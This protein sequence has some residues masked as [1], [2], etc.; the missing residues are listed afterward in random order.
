MNL[1]QPPSSDA[2]LF[3]FRGTF[4]DNT[5]IN[6][7][8]LGCGRPDLIYRNVIGLFSPAFNEI[9]YVVQSLDDDTKEFEV[10]FL[11]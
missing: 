9:Q 8:F 4:Q 11:K 3:Y 6:A 1:S 10:C 2:F 7:H 5:H